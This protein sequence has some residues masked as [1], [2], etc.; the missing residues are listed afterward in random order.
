MYISTQKAQM[1]KANNLN[2]ELTIESILSIGAPSNSFGDSS[3]EGISDVMIAPDDDE[4]RAKK[5]VTST[6]HSSQAQRGRPIVL[7]DD[8]LP[9][10]GTS[11]LQ[12]LD[13]DEQ[14]AKALQDELFLAE[15]SGNPEFAPFTTR[16]QQSRRPNNRAH[17]G[18]PASYNGEFCSIFI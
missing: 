12:Q 14:L 4:E 16:H 10:P 2:M 17:Q 7:P 8:F 9:V 6:A 5:N 13:A 15:L 11:K 1:L 3:S 18:Y